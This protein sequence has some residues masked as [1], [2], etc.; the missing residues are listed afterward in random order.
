MSDLELNTTHCCGLRDLAGIQEYYIKYDAR[1]DECYIPSET[2]KSIVD[3]IKYQL[4]H[5]MDG[6]YVT[7]ATAN[8][9]LE[10]TLGL[11]TIG[12][13][14]ATYIRKHDLGKVVTMKPVRNPNSGNILAVWLWQLNRA[15][16]KK[17]KP[18]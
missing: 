15:K 2:P 18:Q 14:L 12:S 9:G 13:R 1:G 6:A 16:I 4:I 3:F 7:F 11:N 5:A 8:M 10:G 17:F